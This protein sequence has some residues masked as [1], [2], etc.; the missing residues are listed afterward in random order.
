MAAQIR[1]SAIVL[2]GGRYDKTLLSKCLNS[3]SWCDEVIS[4][5]TDGRKGSFSDFR[6]EG[7]RKAKGDWL[8]YIDT[9]EEV[10]GKLRETIQKAKSGSLG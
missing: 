6:N 10:T 9:D 3:V 1:I 7:A 2:V 8:L 5:E 4:I